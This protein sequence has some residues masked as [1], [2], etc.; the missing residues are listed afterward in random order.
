MPA[1]GTPWGYPLRPSGNRAYQ[2]PL[3]QPPDPVQVREMV[4]FEA[5]LSVKRLLVPP[6]VPFDTASIEKESEV[7]EATLTRAYRPDG[8]RS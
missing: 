3:S 6:L 4:P 7:A 8:D 1:T 5:R 2:L